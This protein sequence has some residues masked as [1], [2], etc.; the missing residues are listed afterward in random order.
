M[1]RLL[2]KGNNEHLPKRPAQV[3]RYTLKKPRLNKTIQFTVKIKFST[4]IHFVCYAA[5]ILLVILQYCHRPK[6]LNDAIIDTWH[7]TAPKS[8]SGIIKPSA[9]AGNHLS[10]DT[11]TTNIDA[12]LISNAN[13]GGLYVSVVSESPVSDT[14]APASTP[15]D[16][17]T[18]ASITP[19]VPATCGDNEFANYIYM[20]ESGCSTTALNS[21][22]CYGIGQDCNNVLQTLCGADY[23]CQNA[24]FTTYAIARYG[25]WEQAYDFWLANS[26]W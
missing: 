26:W 4:I 13:G 19:D 17:Q 25:G 5:L 10:T 12:S 23:D 1:V 18:Q 14:S 7:K 20:H 2:I 15:S 11:P 3:M 6:I 24:F 22:G 21:L 8:T 9:K 16:T